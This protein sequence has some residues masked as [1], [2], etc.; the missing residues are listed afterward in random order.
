[1]ARF[2]LLLT[3]NGFA[4]QNLAS[5]MLFARAALNKGHE[6]DHLFLYQDAVYSVA[7]HTDLPADEPDLASELAQFCQQHAIALLFCITAAEKRGVVSDIRPARAGYI[8]AGLAEFAMRQVNI[9]KL[10]QF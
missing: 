4:N 7:A 8:A 3:C 6:I 5:V 2:G 9:D 10:V 1:M